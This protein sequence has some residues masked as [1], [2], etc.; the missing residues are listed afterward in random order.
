MLTR[1]CI[2]FGEQAA[3]GYLSGHRKWEVHCPV[4]DCCECPFE[5]LMERNCLMVEDKHWKRLFNK[6]EKL[7]EEEEEPDDSQN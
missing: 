6:C 1:R 3:E 4:G 5:G 2:K 7:R